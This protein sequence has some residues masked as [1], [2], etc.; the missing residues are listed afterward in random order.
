MFIYANV[1]TVIRGGLLVI[2]SLLGGSCCSLGVFVGAHYGSG[3]EVYLKVFV[4][5]L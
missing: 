3:R 2:V 4:F 1:K 5:N